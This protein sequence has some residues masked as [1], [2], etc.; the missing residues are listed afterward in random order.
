ME[1]L[2]QMVN[3]FFIQMY[4]GVKSAYGLPELVERNS[5]TVIL[6]G[7]EQM[8]LGIGKK[9]QLLANMVGAEK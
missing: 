5:P 1:K 7:L 6:K 2:M 9:A 4:D 3:G 8:V